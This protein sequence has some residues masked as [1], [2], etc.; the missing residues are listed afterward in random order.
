MDGWLHVRIEHR[1]AQVARF[2]PVARLLLTGPRIALDGTVVSRAYVKD[3]L[4]LTPGPH[5]LEIWISL[6][7]ATMHPAALS[8]DIA[9]GMSVV[10]RYRGGA[11]RDAPGHIDL[12]EPL[13]AARLVE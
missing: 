9:P 13:P 5:L 3:T 2:H 1:V 12:G 11:R 4:R 8:L 7:I 6:A 10:A